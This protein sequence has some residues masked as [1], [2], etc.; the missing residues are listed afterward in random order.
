MK[1]KV[2]ACRVYK[3]RDTV[4]RRQSMFLFLITEPP[5][6]VTD[7]PLVFDLTVLPGWHHGVSLDTCLSSLLCPP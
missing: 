1:R 5:S 3:D 4:A 2:Y 7:W 6:V